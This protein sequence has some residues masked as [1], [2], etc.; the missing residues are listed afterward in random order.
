MFLSVSEVSLVTRLFERHDYLRGL[1]AV[2]ELV[3]GDG[4]EPGDVGLLG[5]HLLLEFHRG[6]R[7]GW[8]T[9][10]LQQTQSGVGC[11]IIF[12]LLPLLLEH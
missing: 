4:K 3:L 11:K 5:P 6:A 12:L 9:A 8:R 1:Q 10:E 7:D 2:L